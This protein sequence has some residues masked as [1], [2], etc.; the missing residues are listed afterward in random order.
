LLISKNVTAGSPSD[1]KQDLVRVPMQR[2]KTDTLA[3]QVQ[4]R[5]AHSAP[6]SAICGFI[7]A[8]RERGLSSK[9]NEML[10]QDLRRVDLSA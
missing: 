9:N 7:T 5:F 8:S 1:E 4:T 2:G 6:S 3:K 10:V